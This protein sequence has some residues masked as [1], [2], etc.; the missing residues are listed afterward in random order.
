MIP[1]WK[2]P[3]ITEICFSG[4]DRIRQYRDNIEVLCIIS[5]DEYKKKC[6]AHYIEWTF[7]ENRL[8]AKKNHGLKKALE[9]DWDYL[10][11]LN[12][13]DII[14]NELLDIYDSYFGKWEFFGLRNLR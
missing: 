5:E 10:I 8:G 13:D 1:V 7:F 6:K 11:E 14:K 3:E 2:R 12:S 4:L 9:K